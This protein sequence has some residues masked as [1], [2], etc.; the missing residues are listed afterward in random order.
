MA[1]ITE[2]YQQYVL[3]T[4]NQ[5]TG[6]YQPVHASLIERLLTKKVRITKLHPN[7]N[8][9]FSMPD[10][11]PNYEIIG[12]YVRDF[13][14]NIKK[15]DPPFEEPLIV[16]R[17]STGGYLLLNGHHRWMA[18]LRIGLK[19]VRVQ[20]IN[21][22]SD[23]EIIKRI[24]STDSKAVVS[25]D[26]DEVLLTDNHSPIAGKKMIWPLS[27]VYDKTLRI[28]APTLLNNL[29]ALGFDIWAYTGSL[30]SEDYF[31]TLLKLHGTSINGVICGFYKKRN[32]K[33][34]QDVFS[35]NYALSLHIDN[36]SITCVN[37]A[38]KEYDIINITDNPKDW[39]AD[40]FQ[41]C[42]E[43]YKKYQ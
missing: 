18:A 23:E 16:Q 3:D 34:L 8:D 31:H 20:L 42:Q 25:F 40:V 10:I 22:I 9:E 2:E 4:L 19:R 1:I 12:N 37:T 32:K 30:H 28:N 13:L 29:K 11:G 24:T 6:L 43:V 41:K 26:L 5:Y 33:P 14:W 27:T 39:S 15:G 17:I 21:S 7:P 35:S 36:E 38:T